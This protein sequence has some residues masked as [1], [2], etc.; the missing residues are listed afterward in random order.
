M[1]RRVWHHLLTLS[2]HTFIGT[3]CSH[4]LFTPPVHTC[5]VEQ[6]EDAERRRLEQRQRGRV[7]LVLDAHALDALFRVRARLPRRHAHIRK[8][9]ADRGY[10]LPLHMKD[11]GAAPSSPSEAFR[12]ARLHLEDELQEEL[13]QLLVGEVDA[14]LV[15]G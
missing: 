7:V 2:A 10:A 9:L 15:R 8:V 12:W 14:Q 13:V 11:C 1:R 6:P 5:G 4:R 3:V